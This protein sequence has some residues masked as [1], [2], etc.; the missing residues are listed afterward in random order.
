LL[1]G[2]VSRLEGRWNEVFDPSDVAAADLPGVVRG[3]L[4]LG[5]LDE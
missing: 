3:L 1:T 2:W 4:G 5:A